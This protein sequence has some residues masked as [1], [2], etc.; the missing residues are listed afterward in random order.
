MG[1]RTRSPSKTKD[2]GTKKT[3]GKRP[4]RQDGTNGITQLDV[5]DK[6]LGIRM[7][8]KGY[9]PIPYT[10]KDEKGKRLRVGEKTAEAAEYLAK[11]IWGKE[12]HTAEP[13][14]LEPQYQ[15]ISE[16]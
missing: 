12:E 4:K 1:Q 13:E 7:L 8:R 9:T 2:G 10:L 6:W 14:T 16:K 3:N 5:R 11:H 15:R